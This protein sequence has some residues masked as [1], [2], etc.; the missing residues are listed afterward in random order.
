M[1]PPCSGMQRH[2]AAFTRVCIA[3][4]VAAA[5]LIASAPARAADVSVS[6]A[7]TA[8]N[9]KI[10]ADAI[11]SMVVKNNGAEADALVRAA[12]PFANFAEKRT[13]DRGE[14]AP[15][16]REIR[17]IPIPAHATAK[18]TA[19]G[20]HVVL[21]Q[22]REKLVKGETF[23]CSLRFRKAGPMNVK[24]RIAPGPGE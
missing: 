13:V 21:L 3:L 1:K 24:V 8:P 18:L 9:D 11:L 10:G 22:I 23:D 5:A 6:E 17:S 2:G 7:W 12:C 14:G 19:Q 4:L 15:S 20:Y 16:A